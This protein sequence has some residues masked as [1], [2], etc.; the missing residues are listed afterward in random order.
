MKVFIK[1]GTTHRPAELTPGWDY[2]AN[3]SEMQAWK[4]NCLEEFIG[5]MKMD[6]YVEERDYSVELTEEGMSRIYYQVR[7]KE[8]KDEQLKKAYS[9]PLRNGYFT[10]PA[11][12]IVLIPSENFG[13][14]DRNQSRDEL[15][16]LHCE[17]DEVCKA[18]QH[19]HLGPSELIPDW[20]DGVAAEIRFLNELE[21]E[22]Y[23]D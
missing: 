5:Q 1:G 19:A 17:D 10:Q 21:G 15:G 3:A 6:K 9:P 14:S 23:E 13:G 7:S 8:E 22:D 2:V 4:Q 12:G 16:M 11:D 20:R 18:N